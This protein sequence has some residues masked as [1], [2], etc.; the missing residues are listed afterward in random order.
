MSLPTAGR[1]PVLYPDQFPCA[2]DVLD[3]DAGDLA[4]VALERADLRLPLQPLYLRQ[5][6]AMPAHAPKSVLL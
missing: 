3:V 4:A 2:V 5:P 6:D 1:G